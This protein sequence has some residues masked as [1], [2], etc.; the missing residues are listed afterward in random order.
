MSEF[1]AVKVSVTIATQPTQGVEILI[2]SS[3]HLRL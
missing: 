1:L 2:Q 3:S